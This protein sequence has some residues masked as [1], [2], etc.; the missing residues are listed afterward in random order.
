MSVILTVNPSY[1]VASNE[2]KHT[3]GLG[4]SGPSDLDGR[5]P[6]LILDGN[7]TLGTERIGSMGNQRCSTMASRPPEY[8]IP[9][10]SLA[11]LIHLLSSPLALLVVGL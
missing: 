5:P 1:F 4:E 2:A 8:Q 10:F 6:P 9:I 7:G 3:G 11:A